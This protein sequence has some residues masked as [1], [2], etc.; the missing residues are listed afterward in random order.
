MGI[1]PLAVGAEDLLKQQRHVGFRP[2][3]GVVKENGAGLQNGVH[4]PLDGEFHGG[5]RNSSDQPATK[6]RS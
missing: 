2:S 3:C 1:L 5:H 4:Q 6:F